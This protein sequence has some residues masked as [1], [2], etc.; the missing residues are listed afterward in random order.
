MNLRHVFSVVSLIVFTAG[1][2][3]QDANPVHAKPDQ[4]PADAPPVAALA[5]QAPPKTTD[6]L[7]SFKEVAAKTREA[8]DG[9]TSVWFNSSSNDWKKF[10]LSV[11]K[12]AYDVTR[13]DSLVS[14][15][16]GV[17]TFR[18]PTA[19]IAEG[20]NKS[21]VES[22]NSQ[23]EPSSVAYDWRVTYSYQ[24]DRWT[25]KSVENQIVVKVGLS[26][27]ELTLIDTGWVK[28]KGTFHVEV[29]VPMIEKAAP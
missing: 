15:Y 1:C 21:Q 19:L 23:G 20:R 7:T 13:T 5:D 3:Q 14:P 25:L 24:G 8:V 12:F 17:I 9:Q 4:V 10:H 26:D 29:V 11:N 18:L 16:M 22:S 2:E 27:G 6:P 28:P